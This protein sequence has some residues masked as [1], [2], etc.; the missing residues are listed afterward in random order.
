[1]RH[2]SAHCTWVAYCC[3]PVQC[4]LI[5]LSANI[6]CLDNCVIEVTETVFTHALQPW[7]FLGDTWEHNCLVL[8]DQTSASQPVSQSLRDV[9]LYRCA[10]NTD[11]STVF[12]SCTHHPG[13]CQMTQN[14]SSCASAS[15]AGYILLWERTTVE[16]SQPHY[17]KI[18]LSSCV[19]MSWD[20]TLIVQ[21]FCLTNILVSREEDRVFHQQICMLLRSL[22][23]VI[24]TSL[25]RLEQKSAVLLAI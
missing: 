10:N 13:C 11:S 9:I 3:D 24:M 15:E 12:P 8:L 4:L 21:F 14:T 25:K 22:T 23:Q 17:L 1:M 7:T 20:N 19:K 18:G 6:A 16:N 2:C 5:V